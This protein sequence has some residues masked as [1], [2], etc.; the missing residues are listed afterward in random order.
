MTG[1]AFAAVFRTILTDR[2]ALLMLVGSAILYSFFY[3]SAYSG[4]VATR[5]PV[6]AVDLDQT[7]SS[8]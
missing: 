3:P 4:E 6:V 1:R 5:L 8:R 2:A 7:G